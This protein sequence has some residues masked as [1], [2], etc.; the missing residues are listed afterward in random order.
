M[1]A[2]VAASVMLATLT[3]CGGGGEANAAA[4]TATVTV[5][6]PTK[7]V[8]GSATATKTV[9]RTATATKTVIKTVKPKH[10]A[11]PKVDSGSNA[12]HEGVG[13]SDGGWTIV[14]L[15]LSNDGL[16]SFGG[17]MRVRTDHAASGALFKLT[18]LEP[19]TQHVVASLDGSADNADA[20]ST[21][22]VDLISMDDFEAGDWDYAFQ[23][24]DY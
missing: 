23:A 21:V 2:A 20:G 19:G 17:T 24:S 8:P 9:T 5:P 22:T 13:L 16:G 1:T 4:P 11:K 7:T 3:A 15:N 14:D 12:V 6:G 10:K 18:V